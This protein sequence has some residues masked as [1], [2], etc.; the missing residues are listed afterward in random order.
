MVARNPQTTCEYFEVSPG[1][2]PA[3]QLEASPCRATTTRK[4]TAS[5]HVT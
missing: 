2:A 5:Q 4:K 3:A 1:I